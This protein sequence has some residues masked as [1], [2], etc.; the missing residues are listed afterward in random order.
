MYIIHHECVLYI[1][2]SKDAYFYIYYK[3]LKINIYILSYTE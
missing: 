2:H 3:K 1:N